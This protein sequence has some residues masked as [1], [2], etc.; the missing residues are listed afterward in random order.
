MEPWTIHGAWSVLKFM[1]PEADVPVFQLSID[2]TQPLDWH[3]DMGQ[4][5]QSLR[6][7]GILILG[8]GNVVHNLPKLRMG[9]GAYDWATEFD[10]FAQNLERRDMAAL[11]DQ[12]GLGALLT[13]AHPTTDHY[14]PALTLAGTALQ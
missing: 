5:L 7:R 6:D 2:M 9:V 13:Q 14:I 12:Q 8:S 10:T 3:P 1:Y 11:T 4:Y